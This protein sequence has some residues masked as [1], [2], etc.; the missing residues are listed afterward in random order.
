MT[1]L[2]IVL[3]SLSVSALMFGSFAVWLYYVG[4]ESM[5]DRAREE[6]LRKNREL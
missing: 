6:Y 3:I 5:Y 2:G 4:F 1:L